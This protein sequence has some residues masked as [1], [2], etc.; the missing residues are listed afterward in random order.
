MSTILSIL[1]KLSCFWRDSIFVSLSATML[2]VGTHRTIMRPSLTSCRSQWWWM[3]ICRSFVSKAVSL[4]VSRL[5]VLSLSQSIV[6]RP[7]PH[8]HRVPQTGIENR[9]A[10]GSVLSEGIGSRP[11]TRI[12]LPR[13]T[14]TDPR[15]PQIHN[16]FLIELHKMD[17]SFDKLLLFT[18]V[19]FTLLFTHNNSS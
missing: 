8:P 9:P 17:D 16:Y 18:V 7:R 13:L 5:I 6:I 4:L 15:H 2:A 3:S 12:A 10:C 14:L 19:L 1:R 11:S